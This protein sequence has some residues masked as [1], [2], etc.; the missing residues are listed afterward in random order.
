MRAFLPIFALV[1]SM[2]SA[3]ADLLSVGTN[4]VKNPFASTG[5]AGA[6]LGLTTGRSKFPLTGFKTRST[7]SDVD[8][9]L[10]VPDHLASQNDK[11][12]DAISNTL[13]RRQPQVPFKRPVIA[14]DSLTLES[15]KIGFDT[16]T[17]RIGLEYSS[18]GAAQKP[19]TPPALTQFLNE[20]T[21]N[22][23]S[24]R[25]FPVGEKY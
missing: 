7:G 23:L 21:A 25:W 9:M 11:V 16:Q 13:D 2:G 12:V 20:G 1:L 17:A 3:Q 14:Q 6:S 24:E 4:A 10:Y 8:Y 19:Q 15:R 22:S 18:I 5:S